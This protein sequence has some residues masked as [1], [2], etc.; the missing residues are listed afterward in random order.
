MLDRVLGNAVKVDNSVAMQELQPFL[1]QD[2]GILLTFKLLRDLVVF[3]DL[4]LI[5]IDKQGLSGKKAEY[6][7]IPYKSISHFS[8][9]SA[10]RFDRDTDLKI[11]VKGLDYVIEKK[12]KKGSEV[13][14]EVQRALAHYVLR[15]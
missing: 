1:I 9:E 5:L 2:E 14:L 10:G 12:L 13:L 3:T 4:R 7:S 11:Y 15:G 6:H 8:I